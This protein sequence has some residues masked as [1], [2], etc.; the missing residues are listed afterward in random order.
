MNRRDLLSKGGLYL[1]FAGNRMNRLLAVSSAGAGNMLAHESEGLEPLTAHVSLFRNSVTVGVIQKNGKTLLI[2]SGDA[3]ILSKAAHLGLGRVD[4][5]LYTHYHR[6][7]CSGASQLKQAGVKVS[8]PA[9]EARFFHHA[10]ELWL[11]ADNVLYDSM[12]CRPEMRVLRESVMTDHEIRPGEVFAWEGIPIR[13]LATPGHTDGSLTYLVEFDGKT[14]AF[15][16][17]LLCGDGQIWEFYSLQKAFLGMRADYWGFGGGAS[18]LLESAKTLLSFKPD[19]LIPSHGDVIHDPQQAVRSLEVRLDQV[20]ENFFS[21]TAWRIS[22]YHKKES[23][24][25]PSVPMLPP[26]PSVSLPSWLRKLEGTE[27]SYLIVGEDK[28]AFLFDCG[29]PPVGE[30]LNRLLEA[31]EISGVDAIWA[32]HYHND[33]TTSINAV[34]RRFGAKVYAQRELQDILE[35][36]TAYSMPAL[37]PESIHVDHPLEEGEVIHWKGYTLTAYYFPGQ[38]LYHDGLL[39][40]HDGSRVFMS[41]DSFANWGIDDYCSYNRNFIGKDG[42]IAGYSRCLKLLLRLKPDLLCAAHWGAKPVSDAYL[43]KTLDL[44]NERTAMF[45]RLFPWDDPN[46][47]LDPYWIRAYPYRQSVLPGQRVALEA[48]IYNHSDAPRNA[49]VE[50]RAPHGWKLEKASAATI[51]AH[52]EGRIPLA[53]IAP[54]RPA[55]RRHVLGLAV[56]F[57]QRNLGEFAEAIVDYLD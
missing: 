5:V 42:E 21:L 34:R 27:T 30:V 16:G 52:S 33:H 19:L 45:T 12:N 24:V 47:G 9:S 43:Q 54:L 44:L 56:H 41:G 18:Q 20:M 25:G 2:D 51:P 35:N 11:A 14:I 46:F 57:D 29:F 39:I 50:L 40:E 17:D 31:G 15:I 26:L 38:T 37:Y 55:A 1:G 6:D 3:S 36:P 4:Q 53:A 49:V 48:R 13:A 8:V 10:T 23:A 28:T 22:P 32:T 7:Q